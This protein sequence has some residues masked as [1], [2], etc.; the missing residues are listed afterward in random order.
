MKLH[1][2]ESAVTRHINRTKKRN[3]PKCVHPK[4]YVDDDETHNSTSKPK[5]KDRYYHRV[6]VTIER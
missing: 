1:D 5:R 4:G 6:I 3:N 2:D